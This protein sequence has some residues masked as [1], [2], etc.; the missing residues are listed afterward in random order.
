MCEALSAWQKQ[1]GQY[2][3]CKLRALGII[4][5]NLVILPVNCCFYSVSYSSFKVCLAQNS[6]TLKQKHPLWYNHKRDRYLVHKKTRNDFHLSNN[7]YLNF[8]KITVVYFLNRRLIS[9]GQ[10]WYT[11]ITTRSCRRQVTF[12]AVR[13]SSFKSTS[14]TI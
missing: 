3:R 10:C 12:L 4:P 14:A 7:C 11:N 13:T 9:V 6:H 2:W 8:L 5:H 1:F